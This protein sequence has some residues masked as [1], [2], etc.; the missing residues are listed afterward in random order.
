MLIRMIRI[1]PT[2][3][4]NRKS[5]TL[6]ASFPS[7]VRTT[8]IALLKTSRPL[9]TSILLPRHVRLL[10]EMQERLSQAVSQCLRIRPQSPR[11]LQLE[12]LIE[13]HNECS[14]YNELF[15]DFSTF[16]IDLAT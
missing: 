5:S 3:G 9:L 2:S 12:L 16:F 11:V 4:L 13:T 14:C 8:T 10:M 15:P 7:R 6:D 1:P